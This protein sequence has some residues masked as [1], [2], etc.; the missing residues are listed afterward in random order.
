MV[1]LAIVGN[2]Y[3]DRGALISATLVC[4]CLTSIVAGYA[5]SSF[6]SPYFYP[7]PAKKW[8]RVMVLSRLL[9]PGALFVVTMVLNLDYF[10]LLHHQCDPFHDLLD[11]AGHIYVRELSPS[12]LRHLHSPAL[13]P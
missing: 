2:L 7:N 5:S 9:F 6:Y 8:V 1:T 12:S 4:Y 3:T 13:G 10:V 11:V